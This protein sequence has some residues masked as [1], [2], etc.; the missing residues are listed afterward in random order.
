MIIVI[1]RDT[2]EGMKVGLFER[3]EEAEEQAFEWVEDDYG[4]P[5]IPALGENKSN[6]DRMEALRTLELHMSF[7]VD[8]MKIEIGQTWESD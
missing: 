4:R 2:L 1:Y 7:A 8:I 5:D 6:E 3:L